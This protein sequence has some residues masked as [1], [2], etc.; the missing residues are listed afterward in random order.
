M[1]L[2]YL[3]LSLCLLPA[4]SGQAHHYC[5]KQ[6]INQAARKGT[7]LSPAENEYDVQ[8]VK[9]DINLDNTNTNVSG[10][11]TTL[12]RVTAPGG[13][14]EYVFELNN[15]MTIDS[16]LVDGV[17]SPTVNPVSYL[18]VTTL[19]DTIDENT[20]FTVQVFYHG[21]A[22]NG[23]GFF[24]G[25]VINRTMASGTKITYTMSDDYFAKDW[26]PCKQSLQ[27]KIDSADIW[28]TVPA[29]TKAGSNGL[30]K[31]VTP[32]GSANRY[33]WK[34]KYPID[35]YLISVAVAPYVE[36]KQ[37]VHF[38]NSTDTM[39]VQHYIYD[40]VSI[41]SQYKQAIDSTVY[42]V[43]HFSELFGRY[44]FWKEK[45]GHCTAPLS[46]GMEHQTMTTLGVYTTPLIAHELGHQWWG[47]SV[48][49]SSWSDIWM[50][51]GWAS[52]CE[53]LY[54]E[55]YR[56]ATQATTYRT[57]VFNRVM[58]RPDGSVYVYDTTSVA[59]TFDS[60]LTY[61]KGAAVAHML[62]FVAPD[63]ARFF[64]G[65]KNYQQ[66]Y[67]FKTANTEQF[68]TV[69]ETAYGHDLDTF[70]NQWVYG[71]GYPTYSA[72]WNQAGG[73]IIVELT[74]TT[75]KPSSIPLFHTPIELKILAGTSDTTI[76]IYNNQP[77]QY[78]LLN[79]NR[80]MTG[81]RIDPNNHILNREGTITREAYV[82]VSQL[83]AAAIK[84]FPNPAKDSW[85]VSGLSGQVQV[86]LYN[87]NGQL[88][89]SAKHTAGELI[90][91]A[92]HLPTGQYEMVINDRSRKI[93][94]KLVK[95]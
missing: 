35:Y 46:G 8:Y 85:Q 30:L 32:V 15:N 4:F 3:L 11:A 19:P 93:S 59:R 53:Q 82:S 28:V 70:F 43:D 71:E 5:S 24:N 58:A 36:H 65:L 34:T 18:R 16:V 6:R 74:Q 95:W 45:Y 20:L 57:G 91:P 62:R 86:S 40:T 55:K 38:S 10:N 64:Q 84:V 63:D 22:V 78:V 80:V 48:T 94:R 9:L 25:G 89:W 72:K 23:S 69:M 21:T 52:Y 60:R 17:L 88:V 76:T 29:N 66:Q 83:S 41:Y 81:L 27:D 14:T 68:K 31:Q 13:I 49:Y 92:G 73:L 1:F 33:E 39:L 47:N 2:K 42:M 67:A 12:A 37:T 79:W 87:S 77:V 61:D 75:S 26:W 56:N 44:P 54:I 90:I 51:E 50:S 7:V